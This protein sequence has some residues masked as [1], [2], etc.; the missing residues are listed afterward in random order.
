MEILESLTPRDAL[1]GTET[2]PGNRLLRV[3]IEEK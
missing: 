3:T 2:P 1:P